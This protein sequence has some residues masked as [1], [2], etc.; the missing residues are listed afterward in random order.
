M[1]RIDVIVSAVF[2]TFLSVSHI[3]AHENVDSIPSQFEIVPED[4]VSTII[5]SDDILSADSIATPVLAFRPNPTKATWYAVVCPGLGQIYNRSYWKVPI[6]YGGVATL[7]YL[8]SWNGKMYNDYRNAYQDIM[9]NDPNTNSYEALLYYNSNGDLSWKQ[10]TL[11]RK[12]DYYRRYRDLSIF[13]MTLLYVVSIID[14]FVD[15][16]LYDFSVTE[17]LSLRVEP[18]IKNYYNSQPVPPTTMMGF[19]CTISF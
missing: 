9:D 19:Q 12:R 5:L 6:V 14:A 11:Q 2:F 8:I 1:K 15:A 3:F 4:T 13:G 10:S 7:T 17:D 16:H 18:V